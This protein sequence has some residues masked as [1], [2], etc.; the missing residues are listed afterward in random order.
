MICGTEPGTYEK[1]KLADLKS[2]D[3]VKTVEYSVIH[4]YEGKLPLLISIPVDSGLT[5]VEGEEYDNISDVAKKSGI[6]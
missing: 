2:G 5:K 6:I 1:M 3:I 4:F